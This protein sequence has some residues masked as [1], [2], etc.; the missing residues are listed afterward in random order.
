MY[1]EHLPP[2]ALAPYVDRFWT[3]DATAGPG[4]PRRILPDGCI[5]ILVELD[6]DHASPRVVGTMTRA[7]VIPPGP[8]LRVVA[9]RFRPGAAAAFLRVDAD[10]LTD[11]DVDLPA[12]GLDLAIDPRDPLGSLTRYLLA[13]LPVSPHP[14]AGYAIARLLRAAPSLPELARETGWSRQWL[15]RECRR[16]VG[17]TPKQLS[18]VARL[19]RSIIALQALATRPRVP[20]HGLASLAP[21]LGYFD[22]AHLAKDFRELAGCTPRD[23][24]SIFPIR[25]VYAAP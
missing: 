12:L 21:A 20:S 23:A 5:D 2:A 14:V 6:G 11:L 1:R 16:R 13:R 17:V 19:Q 4:D 3:S 24:L 10:E 25:S 18:R 8:A 22:Q 15:T 9:V 7:L